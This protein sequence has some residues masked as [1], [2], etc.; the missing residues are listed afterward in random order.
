MYNPYNNPTARIG[1]REDP[2]SLALEDATEKGY[3]WMPRF[4]SDPEA[5]CFVYDNLEDILKLPDYGY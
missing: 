2:M 4:L 1:V 5:S 3:A